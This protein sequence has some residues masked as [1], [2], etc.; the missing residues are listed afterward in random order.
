MTIIMIGT[1]NGVFGAAGDSRTIVD[2]ASGDQEKKTFSLY[3]GKIVGA[4]EFIMSLAGKSIGEW[5]VQIPEGFSSP[6]SLQQFI[7]L[8]VPYYLSFLNNTTID[9]FWLEGRSSN[10]LL[11]SKKD[12][13]GPTFEKALLKFS[14]REGCVQLN[15]QPSAMRFESN[16]KKVSTGN[17]NAKKAAEDFFDENKKRIGDLEALLKG[18]IKAGIKAAEAEND[19]SIGDE[20]TIEIGV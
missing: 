8:F 15:N 16:N 13:S 9:S 3:N 6:C 10:V 19:N 5:I 1:K 7:R 4:F 12:F 20:P 17:A 11:V 14:Y 18:S 2:N